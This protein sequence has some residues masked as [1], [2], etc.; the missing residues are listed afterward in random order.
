LQGYW[1]LVEAMTE[2]PPAERLAAARD[3]LAATKTSAE[4]KLGLARLAELRGPEA[5]E[6]AQGYRH[7]AAV[8]AEAEV[9]C[10]RIVSRLDAAN[11]AGVMVVLRNLATEAENPRVRNEAKTLAAKVEAQVGCLAPWLVCGPYRQSGKEAQQLFDVAFP[12]EGVGAADVKWRPLPMS[13]GLTNFGFADLG[14]VVGGDH[15]IVYLKTR[16]F[17]PK[18]QPIALEIGTDDGVKLWV[19][20]ALVHA[21]NAVRGFSP[22]AD[23]AQGLIK[24]GW[25]EFLVKVTQHTAGCAAQVR[26]RAADGSAIPGLRVGVQ[27]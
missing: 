7:N 21:N 6:L 12:P 19:N 14:P 18:E 27:E 9:A 8:R 11:L 5:L 1:R 4:Q 25:N 10:L 17:S 3:G 20:G 23:K 26:V 22:G 24:E 15:C 2:R 13:G 16:V